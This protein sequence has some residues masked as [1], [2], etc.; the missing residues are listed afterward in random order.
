MRVCS[1]RYLAQHGKEIDRCRGH[2]PHDKT[3]AEFEGLVQELDEDSAKE[4]E[5]EDPDPSVGMTYC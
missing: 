2:P 1:P 4:R 3:Q 5:E